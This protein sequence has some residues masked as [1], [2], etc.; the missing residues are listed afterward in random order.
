VNTDLD[1]SKCEHINIDNSE[2]ENINIDNSECEHSYID[3][4]EC[5][6][7]K[8]Q[9]NQDHFIY[10]YFLRSIITDPITS[11]KHVHSRA[12]SLAVH[13]CLVHR[14]LKEEYEL[15]FLSE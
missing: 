12:Q 13:A 11:T 7:T 15:K 14:T 10:S 9:R 1:T 3:A 6:H 2:Y 8:W 5:E 4:S